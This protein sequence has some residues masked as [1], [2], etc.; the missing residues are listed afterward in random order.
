MIIKRE[1]EKKIEKKTKKQDLKV[2]VYLVEILRDQ[3]ET[4]KLF[5]EFL[6]KRKRNKIEKI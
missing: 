6:K 2:L 1:R 3:R 5:D 4:A